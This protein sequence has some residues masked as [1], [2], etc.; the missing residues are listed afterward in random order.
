MEKQGLRKFLIFALIY[1]VLVII[2]LSNP[3]Y[4]Y[5][6]VFSAESETY[7]I[8]G[9]EA[10]EK[11]D[12]DTAIEWYQKAAILEPKYAAPH[13][14]LGILF[15]T[16]GWLD[17]AEAEYQKTLAI[18]PN[19]CDAH[20]NLA[21]LYERKGELEKAAFHWMRRYKLGK[22]GDPWTT[23]AKNRLEKLGL[24]EK[25]ESGE[26]QA[27]QK[28]EVTPPPA[29]KAATKEVTAEKKAQKPKE[30]AAKKQTPK[31]GKTSKWTRVGQENKAPEVKEPKKISKPIAPSVSN[32]KSKSSM[33]EELQES[34]RLA[35]EKLK[36]ER[37]NK[38]QV[39]QETSGVRPSSQAG[40]YYSKASD[41]YN[42]GEYSRA[43]DTIR[44]AKK[45]FPDDRALSALEQDIKN[46]MKEERITD[47]YNEGMKCYRQKDFAGAR[48]NFESI[49]NILPD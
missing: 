18:D 21:L 35:E 33:D 38:T 4:I 25:A 16:K 3:N 34:L 30:P 12:I 19:Y 7:R 14:D 46:K 40:T 44:V 39:R 29:V 15:E 26:A 9:Y 6:G 47:L 37:R 24:L 49:L 11:G 48:R 31:K 45:D 27:S 43:L 32:V 41:Y 13:N 42:R 17:K 20:T 22:P 36:E 23:E 8:N 1:P 5:A 10:Q 2:S 28:K